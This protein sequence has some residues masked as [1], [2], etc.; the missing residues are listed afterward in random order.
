MLAQLALP[1]GVG[2]TVVADCV[3]VPVGLVFEL[4]GVTGALAVGVAD[5]VAVTVTVLVGVVL[6]GVAG[7]ELTEVW[8]P[9]A[10]T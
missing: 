7:L 4:D 2:V 8:P 6:L 3:G 9:A 5:D 1:D 10:G